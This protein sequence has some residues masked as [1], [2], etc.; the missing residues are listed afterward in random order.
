MYWQ[1]DSELLEPLEVEGC[2]QEFVDQPR[3]TA[4]LHPLHSSMRISSQEVNAFV[5][6][7]GDASLS[8]LAL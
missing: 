3:P 8:Q 4:D 1:K 6:S 7:R 2:L 5:S